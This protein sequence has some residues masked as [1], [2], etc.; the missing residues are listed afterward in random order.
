M[1]DNAPLQ[2]TP[3]VEPV[4]QIVEVGDPLLSSH[5]IV[6][7]SAPLSLTVTMRV[8]G[9]EE[10]VGGIEDHLQHLFNRLDRTIQLIRLLQNVDRWTQT[11]RSFFLRAASLVCW[12]TWYRTQRSHRRP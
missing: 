4:G 12:S 8:I 7:T 10:Y 3:V 2:P 9:K 1:T 11:E 6:T 5:I